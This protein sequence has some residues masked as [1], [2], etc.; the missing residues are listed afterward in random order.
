MYP[1]SRV[2]SF[3][4]FFQG[5]LLLEVTLLKLFF[6]L[7][8]G[9]GMVLNSFGTVLNNTRKNFK[10]FQRVPPP[11][12]RLCR[13]TPNYLIKADVTSRLRKNL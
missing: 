11:P 3:V 8:I 7:I 13:C 6:S 1:P 12:P 5:N 4:Q 10:K 9:S 2:Y